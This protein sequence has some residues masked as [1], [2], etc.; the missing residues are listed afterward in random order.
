MSL[1]SRLVE[2]KKVRYEKY[3]E[4]SVQFGTCCWLG[5]GHTGHISSNRS[6]VLLAVC[7]FSQQAAEIAFLGEMENGSSVQLVDHK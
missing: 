5:W 2:K 6:R 3:V 7:Q 4:N 1:S